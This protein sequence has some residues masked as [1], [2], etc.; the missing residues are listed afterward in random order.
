MSDWLLK[1]EPKAVQVEALRRANGKR[2]FAFFMDMGLG[3]TAATYADYLTWQREG[4]ADCMVVVCPH[5]LRGTWKEQAIEWGITEDHEIYIWPATPENLDRR[6]SPFVWIFN[7]ESL[8]VGRALGVQAIEVLTESKQVFLVVDESISIKKHNAKR[9]VA[10]INFAKDCAAVRLLSGEPVSQ[11]PHDLWAQFRAMGWEGN[12]FGFRNRYCRMG[13]FKG[14]SV[15]GAQN[16]DQLNRLINQWGFR[17]RKKDWGLD[18]PVSFLT[19]HYEMD[20]GQLACYRDMEDEF[21]ILLEDDAVTAEMVI[22]QMLR[23]QQ[24][25]SGFV[26]TDSGDVREVTRT[27]PK[28][29]AIDELIEENSRLKPIVFT[30]FKPSTAMLVERMEKHNF[31]RIIGGMSG[32]EIEKEKRRFNNDDTVGGAI[33]QTQ[34]GM[35]GHTLLG[36]E[37]RPADTM[38]Y[39][40]N[41][42]DLNARLQS[43]DRNNRWGQTAESLNCIDLIG[44]EIEARAIKAL[45]RK[46]DV[47]RSVVDGIKNVQRTST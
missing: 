45:V 18:I 21:M 17:A 7:Y 46:E 22:T 36:T 8:S 13:G 6:N 43:L 33:C 19:R 26:G 30:Y 20:A 27:H 9:T 32:D 1:G 12:Y 44:T 5:T 10:I 25:S 28:A 38:I 3:K 31:I 42:Y 37:A 24:I 2:G 40:E 29:R 4:D 15:I 39:Y 16:E 41:S 23:L 35:Y 11:G 34:V 14:K 47:A